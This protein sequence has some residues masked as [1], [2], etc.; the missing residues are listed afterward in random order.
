MVDISKLKNDLKEFEENKENFD[1]D[2]YNDMMEEFENDDPKDILYEVF[3][4]ESLGWE[5][6]DRFYIPVGAGL[7]ELSPTE[8][9][10]I[11][12][13]VGK[14]NREHG[15]I[16]MDDFN[17]LYNNVV[18][19]DYIKDIT[20]E[21]INA[22]NKGYAEGKVTFANVPT[23]DLDV[24]DAISQSDIENIPDLKL[25]NKEPGWNVFRNVSDMNIS[26]N[27]RNGLKAVNL[28]QEDNSVVRMLVNERFIHYADVNSVGN[29]KFNIA[30]PASY[31]EL[32][33]KFPNEDH[34]SKCPVDKLLDIHNESLSRSAE[35]MKNNESLNEIESEN[36]AEATAVEEAPTIE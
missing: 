32:P 2:F 27:A 13:Q 16:S 10:A 11:Y 25:E 17:T 21:E 35:Y 12:T 14:E 3:T 28:Y 22:L 19:N 24:I 4:D 9:F 18:D 5:D 36:E 26:K 15:G 31:K 20:I 8:Y 1:S 33:A 6:I 29:D 7:N 30:L 34:Y 23:V